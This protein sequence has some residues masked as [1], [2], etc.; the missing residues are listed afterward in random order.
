[1]IHPA[2]KDKNAKAKPWS[3]QIR[4][5][6]DGKGRN[7]YIGYFAREEDAARARDRVS[8]A[9]LGHAE[10]KSRGGVGGARGAGRG[11]GGGVDAGACG[12]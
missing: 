7:S 11:R 5:T 4:V 12:R 6:E 3:A 10:A 8:T 9:K 1:M 2:G